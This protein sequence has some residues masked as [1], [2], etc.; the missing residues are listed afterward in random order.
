M[1]GQPSHEEP[2]LLDYY[3]VS[4][5]GRSKA[6]IN[7]L[8]GRK[9]VRLGDVEEADLV[10]ADGTPGPFNFRQ[11]IQQEYTLADRE[12]LTRLKAA[13]RKTG[14]PVHFIDFETSRV[15]VPYHARMRRT[16]KW[17]SSGVVTR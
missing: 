1:L 4:S 3:H 12:N 9:R 8:I 5:I 7:A 17:R 16:S 13:P 10:K 6:L 2:N 11:R 14:V 15:A